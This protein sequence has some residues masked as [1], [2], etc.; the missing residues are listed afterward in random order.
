MLATQLEG[1]HLYNSERLRLFL[2]AVC[3][4]PRRPNNPRKMMDIARSFQMRQQIAGNSLAAWNTQLPA[5]VGYTQE[6]GVQLFLGTHR[7]GAAVSVGGILLP[8]VVWS[9][10][11]VWEAYG[12][13]E[14]WEALM[15]SGNPLPRI[16]L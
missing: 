8:V 13:L 3:T 10:A 16:S 11:E 1:I 5:L 4:P 15:T 9:L 6:H 7:W 14:K 2:P 12:D